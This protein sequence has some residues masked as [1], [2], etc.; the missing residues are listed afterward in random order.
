MEEAEDCQSCAG[1]ITWPNNIEQTGEGD[2]IE[3]AEEVMETFAQHFDIG[4]DNEVAHLKGEHFDEYRGIAAV[5]VDGVVEEDEDIEH[6]EFGEKS[7]LLIWHV[8]LVG[9][10]VADFLVVIQSLQLPPPE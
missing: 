3:H 10:G 1:H 9:S 7:N 8:L 6:S 4:E 5:A 2:C